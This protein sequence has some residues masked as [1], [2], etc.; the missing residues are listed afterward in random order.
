MEGVWCV[1]F[2]YKVCPR[3]SSHAVVKTLVSIQAV[4]SVIYVKL[5]KNVSWRILLVAF[6]Y[7]LTVCCIWKNQQ[8][9]STQGRI[10]FCLYLSVWGNTDVRSQEIHRRKKRK[11]RTKPVPL[12]PEC[13][14]NVLMKVSI[15]GWCS[16]CW[17]L[18]L[19]FLMSLSAQEHH[20]SLIFRGWT[21]TLPCRKESGLGD[22]LCP[23]ASSDQWACLWLG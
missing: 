15:P 11:C 20:R 1:F 18:L 7:L 12:Y 5:Q 2:L 17:K 10:H 8:N 9:A 16:V 22:M 6:L 13:V 23:N 4:M 14:R 19:T 21:S 3:I